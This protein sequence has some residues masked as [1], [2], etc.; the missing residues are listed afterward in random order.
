MAETVPHLCSAD[1]PAPRCVFLDRDGTLIVDKH[2]LMDPAGVE[3]IDG[4]AEA[5]EKLL[6]SGAELHLFSNQSGI[7]RGMYT[8]REVEAC[9]ERLLELLGLGPN[10]FAGICIAPEAE[11]VEGGY[12]KPSPRYIDE[13]LARRKFERG[14]CVVVGDRRSDW[15]AGIA[16][17]IGAVAVR[18]GKHWDDSDRE[19]IR[20]HGVSEYPDLRTW[21]NSIYSAS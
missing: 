18:T 19:Y 21:V 5:M 14:D 7:G 16:A 12:R 1:G 13:V 20:S 3:L 10:V 8:M 15:Q 2:Y 11:T 4:V 9:N 6:R 17:G